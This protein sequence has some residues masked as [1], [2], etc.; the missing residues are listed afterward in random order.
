MNV[1]QTMTRFGVGVLTALCV[2]SFLAVGF[3]AGPN[4]EGIVPAE[5]AKTPD[6]YAKVIKEPDPA[7]LGSWECVHMRSSKV[8]GEYSPEPVQFHLAKR[9]DK[10]A[11]FFHR[12]KPSTNRVYTGWRDWEINGKEIKS[13]TGVRIVA[14]GDRVFY[15]WKDDKPTEMTRFEIK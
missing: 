1:R 12:F 13:E 11:L 2:A 8:P 14:E 4:P 3:A 10:Y 5:I 15:V 7:L 9:G 6:M